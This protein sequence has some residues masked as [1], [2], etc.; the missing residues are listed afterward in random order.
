MRRT[1]L[2]RG[3]AALIAATAVAL[4]G[5][6]DNTDATTTRVGTAT[7]SPVQG[8]TADLPQAAARLQQDTYKMTMTM[9]VGGDSGRLTGLIDPQKDVGA[10]TAT[11]DRSGT[12]ATQWLVI[13]NVVYLRMTAPNTAGPDGK[14]WRRINS[15]ATSADGYDGTAMS[16]SLE[17]A[18][19]VQ[20]AGDHEFTGT[21]DLA[22]S[23]KALGVP[24]PQVSQTG[25]ARVPFEAATDTAGRLVRYTLNT[26]GGDNGT[27]NATI[28]FSDFGVPVNVQA[29][30]ASQISTT[31]DR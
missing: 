15:G 4:G 16:T 1:M 30:P 5:C 29:P 6:S 17:K 20:R 25:P 18:A 9:Q 13:G 24:A 14:T 19:D 27:S 7:F 31:S 10:Y 3:P 12:S 2:I 21:L 26:P 8:P 28:T 23:A 11:T 22:A